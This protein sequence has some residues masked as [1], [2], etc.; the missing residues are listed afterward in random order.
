MKALHYTEVEGVR[1]IGELDLPE[2]KD[3]EVVVDMAY[4]GINSIDG[5][6]WKALGG[7][8]PTSPHVPGVEGSGWVDGKPVMLFG[9]GLGV[10]RWGVAAEKV[11]A[12]K[13]ALFDI[14]AGLDMAHAAVCGAAGA[15]AMRLYELTEAKAGDCVVVHA[16]DGAV[17]TILTSL[18]VGNDV[19]VL[20]QTLNEEKAKTITLAGGQPIIATNADEFATKLA[21]TG[22][23]PVACVDVLGGDYTQASADVLGIG[24]RILTYGALAGPMKLDTLPFYRK[25]LTLR[26][27]SGLSDPQAHARCVGFALQAASEGKLMIEPILRRYPFEQANEAFEAILGGV[28]GKALLRIKD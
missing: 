3:G 16:C 6:I 23:T 10:M 21:D 9:A 27:Y 1:S 22:I 17:G 8:K 13:Q 20:G 25:G 7:L 15:T 2:P 5:Q 28:P 4:A 19:R 18:L 11:V 14:P 26:G 12:P 24:G